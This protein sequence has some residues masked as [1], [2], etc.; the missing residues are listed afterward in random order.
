ML[1]QA[2]TLDDFGEGQSNRRR[3]TCTEYKLQ[4]RFDRQ[5]QQQH[6]SIRCAASVQH[7]VAAY[8]VEVC[9][10]LAL[11]CLLQCSGQTGLQALQTQ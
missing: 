8:L 3:N 10:Q 2:A 9:S 4:L 7:N 5:L 1:T 6:S 11:L